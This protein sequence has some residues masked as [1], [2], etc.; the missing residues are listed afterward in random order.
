MRKRREFTNEF[1][2]DAV[3]LAEIVWV[4]PDAQ[5]TL[6]RGDRPARHRQIRTHDTDAAGGATPHWRCRGSDASGATQQGGFEVSRSPHQFC[7]TTPRGSG[8]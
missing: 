1:E 4:H 6:V 5:R 7:Q 3:K 8:G 2:L